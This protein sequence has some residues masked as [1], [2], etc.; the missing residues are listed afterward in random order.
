MCTRQSL[1]VA[2]GLLI[3]GTLHAAQ[4]SNDKLETLG[5]GDVLIFSAPPRETAEEGVAIYQPV[6]AYF[7]KVTGKRVIYRHPRTYGIYRTEMVNGVYDIAFDGAH[8]NGYRVQKLNHNILARVPG[9]RNFVV[10]TQKGEK[11]NTIADL[12]GKAVCVQ[13]PPNLSAL[14]LLS[15][16]DN[17]ARQPFIVPRKGHD[18]I[19][20]GV[21]SGH[22]TAGIMPKPNLKTVDTG[23]IKILFE[24]PMI[25]DQ[26]FSAGPRV[27]REDQ[28]KLSA[29]LLSTESA[30]VTEKLR[31]KFKIGDNLVAGTN[32]EYA[33]F[34]DLLRH[35]WGFRDEK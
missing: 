34:A 35:E 25:A 32:K 29:A 12:A 7:S 33:P 13:P 4:Q 20:Q 19:Y 10:I 17:P 3:S 31:A 16:F 14:L 26:A 15:Q 11:I 30:S 24:S 1:L 8:F 5:R 2:M 23:V 21:V 18:A 28:V 27:T 22:C 6:A 9:D